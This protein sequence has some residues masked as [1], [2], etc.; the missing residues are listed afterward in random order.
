MFGSRKRRI[1][2]F[3]VIAVLLVVI[4]LSYIAINE[5]V[6]ISVHS[7]PAEMHASGD[8]YNYSGAFGNYSNGIWASP[9]N[10]TASAAINET[11]FSPSFLYLEISD[12][13]AFYYGN[14]P[15][16]PIMFMFC[17]SYWGNLSPNLHPTGLEFQ[18]SESPASGTGYGGI[19]G[20]IFANFQSNRTT[21][22]SSVSVQPTSA[23]LTTYTAFIGLLNEPHYSIFSGYG[24]QRYHFGFPPTIQD[25]TIIPFVGT[26]VFDF[27]IVILGLYEP[28]VATVQFFLTS[29]VYFV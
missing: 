18:V 6:P 2:I 13:D 16:G 23:S 9:E 28:V 8:F 17:L 3:S 21:N 19:H 14:G 10:A 27:S 11:G 20:F 29:I 26:F 15:N 22:I 12:M 7:V 24:T 5:K 1:V 25:V 4:P